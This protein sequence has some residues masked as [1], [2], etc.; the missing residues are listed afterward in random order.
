MASRV[1]KA[2]AKDVYRGYIPE[3]LPQNK[4]PSRIRPWW[5][6]AGKPRVTVYPQPIPFDKKD[7]YTDEPQYPPLN[8]GSRWGLKRQIRLDWYEK[9]K[10]LPT[11]EMKMYE[12][13]KHCEHYIAHFNNWLPN[14]NSLP[15]IKYMT[16]THLIDSLPLAYQEPKPN[17]DKQDDIESSVEKILL[18][19]I[20][21]D[22]YESCKTKPHYV[23]KTIRGDNDRNQFI[24]IR[25][26]QNMITGIKSVIATDKN[27]QIL[28]YQYD[29]SPAIRSWWYHSG[30]QPP[31]KKPFYKSRTDDDGNINQMIQMDGAAALNIRSDNLIEPILPFD[32]DII[33]DENLVDKFNYSL[34]Y[35]GAKYKFK[36]PVALPGFWFEEKP[37]YDCPHTTFLTTDCLTTRSLH[38]KNCIRPIDDQENCLNGQAIMTAFGWLNSLSCYHGFTPF[39]EL[40]YPFTC[41]VVTTNGQEWLFHVYQL[42]SHAFHRDL[43]I[44]VRNNICWSSGVMK[45]YGSYEDGQFNDVNKDVIKLLVKFMS[46]QTSPA[47]TQQLNLRPYLSEPV[48][49]TEEQL[50]EAR[51]RLRRNLEQ[52]SNKYMKHN[53]SI[54]TWE[55]IYFHHK[56]MRQTI[57][58]ERPLYHPPKPKYPKK[59]D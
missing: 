33:N 14:Y 25:N 19:Q 32:S 51:Q 18:N 50:N 37:K 40:S 55:H 27:D 45:L 56:E 12:I 3:G 43:E 35:Y 1:A 21:L 5:K 22:L 26:I 30:F 57:T 59:F 20:A 10:S 46:Q 41:Q 38:I 31:N 36:R 49:Q 52:R 15:M 29:Y 9:L 2:A 58:C 47:Y 4:P 34:A 42:N 28:D 39:H 17:G 24:S 6:V 16:R 48:D 11:A 44:P 13:T 53:W 7:Q 23:S 54:P 8:D